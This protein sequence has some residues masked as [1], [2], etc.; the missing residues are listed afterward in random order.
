MSLAANIKKNLRKMRKAKPRRA[1]RSRV[2]RLGVLSKLSKYDMKHYNYKF[3]LTPQVLTQALAG[4]GSM[5]LSVSSGQAPIFGAPSTGIMSQTTLTP[6][7]N[8]LANF[9]DLA[10]AIPF[11][12]SDVANYLPFTSMYDAYKLNKVSLK[13]EYLSNT[14]AVNG[15]GLMPTLYTY[16]DLD[17][18]V[19]PNPFLI[20][21]RQGV[22]IQQFG[23]RSK[24]ALGTALRPAV[25][26]A[27]STITTGAVPAGIGKP[28]WI[29]CA[30]FDVWH[31]ALKFA[32][33]DIFLPVTAGQ[34][35]QAF[36]FQWTYDVSFRTP[37]ITR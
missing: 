20:T 3:H 18:A 14:A 32:I 25:Q 2:P 5:V 4:G 22:K 31:Y 8:G 10:G 15:V 30:Q 11:K 13:I 19:I 12:L 1:R 28:Q 34:I 9:Y 26:Q 17:D 35:S 27:L 7:T 16:A 36:R 37:L 23:N 6:S 33:T 29:N 24:T 21:G